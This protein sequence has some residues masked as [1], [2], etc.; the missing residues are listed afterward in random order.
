MQRSLKSCAPLPLET[1]STPPFTVVIAYEDFDTGTHARKT[2]EYLVRNLEGVQNFSHQ[3]WKFDV[4]QIPKLREIAARDA[5]QADLIMISCRGTHDLPE[6]VREW[7][8]RWL[9]QK[10]EPAGLVLLFDAP[11]DAYKA[12]DVSKYLAGVARRAGIEFFSQPSW[13]KLGSSR[14][15]LDFGVREKGDARIFFSLSGM[16]SKSAPVARWGI[17]E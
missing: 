10:G 14:P 7:N 15:A 13:N 12:A 6:H 5:A 1:E 4:L 9:A 3:M 11:R 17:N 2:Y 16:E 8:E